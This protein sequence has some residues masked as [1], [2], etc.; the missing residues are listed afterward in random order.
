MEKESNEIEKN[1]QVDSIT[2]KRTLVTEDLAE[3]LLFNPLNNLLDLNKTP[4]Q[5]NIS[6]PID[7]YN[8]F[9][10]KLKENYKVTNLDVSSINDEL[11]CQIEK[12]VDFSSFIITDSNKNADYSQESAVINRY[13][14]LFNNYVNMV[15][16][17]G[18][19]YIL[20]DSYSCCLFQDLIKNALNNNNDNTENNSN[21]LKLY[22]NFLIKAYIIDS[23]PLILL[24]IQIFHQ[25]TKVELNNLKVRIILNLETAYHNKSSPLCE[26]VELSLFYNEIIYNTELKKDKNYLRE[27]YHKGEIVRSNLKTYAIFKLN[28]KSDNLYSKRLSYTVIVADSENQEL[29][30][31]NTCKAL[32]LTSNLS[33]MIYELSQ[34]NYQNLINQFQLS[35]LILIKPSCFCLNSVEDIKLNISPYL[36]NF[37]HKDYSGKDIEILFFKDTRTD[38]NIV[39]SYN[40]NNESTKVNSNYSVVDVKGS[41]NFY[42]RQIIDQYDLIIDE[43]AINHI[44]KN[45]SK[46]SNYKILPGPKNIESKN[47]KVVLSENGIVSQEYQACLASLFFLN[48][49]KIVVENQ[50]NLSMLFLN[51]CTGAIPY[52]ASKFI[53]DRTN[54]VSVENNK[55][56]I[57]IGTKYIGLNNDTDNTEKKL[58]SKL[59]N[60]YYVDFIK[61][62]ALNTKYKN[63]F[64]IVYLVNNKIEDYSDKTSPSKN[65]FCDKVIDNLQKIMDDNSVFCISIKSDS[66]EDYNRCIKLLKKYFNKIYFLDTYDNL[67]RLHFA[68][69]GFDSS[70]IL[71][72]DIFKPNLEL[73]SSDEEGKIFD[74]RIL[75]EYG[76]FFERLVEM[77]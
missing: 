70:K 75:H 4:L 77:E 2:I 21:N 54:I 17:M 36:E 19:V 64:N 25:K 43:F 42:I 10:N 58:T 15:K 71:F 30:S 1:Q 12:I 55:D 48:I 14:N 34:N 47:L 68:L 53:K 72:L 32:I 69:K 65:F 18:Y 33:S 66:K 38:R 50:N 52:Y 3:T 74:K 76:F 5:S 45:D 51:S 26:D 31:K 56:L 29:I 27:N 6:I 39:L 7:T 11:T 46:A 62:T 63:K 28:N 24:S 9:K 60:S 57:Q 22:N 16:N 8:K 35:R 59:Y 20:L 61:D 73:Y 41:N 49:K 67:N 37:I 13:S 23:T 40:N 44:S